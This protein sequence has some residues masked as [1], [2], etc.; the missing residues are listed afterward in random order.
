MKLNRDKGSDKDKDVG[1]HQDKGSQQQQQDQGLNKGLGKGLD[2]H[3]MTSSSSS[4]SSSSFSSSSFLHLRDDL[5]TSLS[6]G[7]LQLLKL[8]SVAVACKSLGNEA[9]KHKQTAAAVVLYN[10][11]LS[12]L[13][14]IV[15]G[16]QFD[17]NSLLTYS[18]MRGM[19]HRSSLLSGG[20]DQVRIHSFDT[21]YG[22]VF[23]LIIILILISS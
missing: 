14:F 8:Y 1:L 3:E 13:N 22:L 12:Y 21:D 7:F 18:S 23:I 10:K 17:P 11:S 16:L 20:K 4:S 5:V 15:L 6:L 19:H 9:F 2:K